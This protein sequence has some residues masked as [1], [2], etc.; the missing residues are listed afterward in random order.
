MM[1]RKATAAD[2][3]AIAAIYNALL[4]REEQGLL[5]TGWTRGIY[6]T[7]QTALDALTAGTL[8]VLEDEGRVTAAAKIDQHQ[9]PQYAQCPWQY[10]APPERVLVLHTLVVD[11]AVKGKRVWHRLRPVLRAVG[12]RDGA[13]LPAHRHQCPQ[14]PRPHP[15]RPSGL[16]RGGHHRRQLQRYPRRTAGLSGKNRL[17]VAYAADIRQNIPYTKENHPRRRTCHGHCTRNDAEL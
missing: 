12:P 5:T 8:Y 3:P 17:I 14:H 15:V 6:P 1:I 7:E 2:I 11:P 16:Y 4:D 9:M 10:E 13:E